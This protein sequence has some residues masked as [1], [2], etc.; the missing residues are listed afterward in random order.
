MRYFLVALGA[1][2]LTVGGL[3]LLGWAPLP[4]TVKLDNKRV[5]VKEV[6]YLP[7]VARERYTRPTDQVIVFLDDSKYE[8]IDSTTKER[9][10]RE[11]KS[12]E[13]LWHDKGEDA[14]VLRNLG[15]KPY[16]SLVI[17]LK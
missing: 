2:A 9:T 3:R 11:R 16:R 10:V 7:G 17:E 8:R 6:L 15:T 4:E 13:V 12:G 5:R 14:P 1:C